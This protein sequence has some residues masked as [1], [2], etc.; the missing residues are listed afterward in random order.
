MY[1]PG[2]NWNRKIEL[3]KRILMLM[4]NMLIKYLDSRNMNQNLYN[5]MSILINR[6]QNF[7]K[8][9]MIKY[10]FGNKISKVLRMT[11]MIFKFHLGKTY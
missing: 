8:I 9:E 3:V 2:S 7:Q 6:F 1:V 11:L 10:I 5:N 4:Y